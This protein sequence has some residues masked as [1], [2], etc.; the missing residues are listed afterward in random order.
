MP[1]T[2][3]NSELE[4]AITD[5]H[6]RA[7]RLITDANQSHLLPKQVRKHHNS[8]VELILNDNDTSLAGEYAELDDLANVLRDA[9]HD[10]N[11]LLG[12]RNAYAE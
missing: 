9:L 8:V 12:G 1:K 5:L 3:L 11:F 10:I 7:E 4:P 6:P 2:P